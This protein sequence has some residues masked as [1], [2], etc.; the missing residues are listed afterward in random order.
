MPFGTVP[1]E[2]FDKSYAGSVST[3]SN[4]ASGRTGLASIL[5][6]SFVTKQLARIF[7]RNLPCR[8]RLKAAENFSGKD[9]SCPRKVRAR[10]EMVDADNGRGMHDV[11]CLRVLQ[12]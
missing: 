12:S 7:E 5:R 6:C 4:V 3:I 11:G 9:I 1:S 8:T 2:H 10:Q